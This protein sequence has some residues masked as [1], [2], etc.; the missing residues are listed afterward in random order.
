[1]SC[2]TTIFISA[3]FLSSFLASNAQTPSAPP[4]DWFLRDPETDLLQGV[5]A[6]RA[7]SSLLKD[8]PSRTVIVAVVDSG[9]DIEHEDLKV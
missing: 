6:E 9:I 3:L 5:S 8:Q 7:Y 1:M 4:T 2:R